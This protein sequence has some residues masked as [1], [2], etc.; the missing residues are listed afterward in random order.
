MFVGGI[1][2]MVNPMNVYITQLAESARDNC[3]K[4]G[5]IE[6]NQYRL[7][8]DTILKI[9]KFFNGELIKPDDKK[10][11]ELFEKYSNKDSNSFMLKKDD[12]SFIIG[13]KEFKL[14]DVLHELGHVF[15][16]FNEM[17]VGEFRSCNDPQGDASELDAS[18]FARV[19]AMP[20]RLFESSVLKNTHNKIC[21]INSV[22]E[23]FGVDYLQVVSHGRES[24]Y[25]D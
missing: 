16:E 4:K 18:K 6:K 24:Y 7:N 1:R 15:L 21:N 13:Y 17:K 14:M 9:V 5:I 10:C 22:A 20:S 2:I 19:F 25:W 3:E 12:N 23:T 8:E 11:N